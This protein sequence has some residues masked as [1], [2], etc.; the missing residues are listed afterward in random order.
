MSSGEPAL[1]EHIAE[2][3]RR[4]G[5]V[6]FA[7]LME[8]ALYHPEHGYY[9]S[10]RCTIGRAGDYFTSVSVGPLFGQLLAAQFAEMWQAMGRPRDF[11]IVE[12]AAHGGEFACD[13]L[14]AARRN[15]SEFFRA[16]R[17]EIIEP[18]P[19]L[20]ARQKKML[21]AFQDKVSWER[22]VADLAPFCGAH[23]SNELLDAM[24]IH[25]VKW[26]G[27]EWLERHVNEHNG[28]LVF[29]DLRLSQPALAE[30]LRK[31]AI[32]LPP[33]YESE[34]SLAT[35]SWIETLSRKLIEGF[36]LTVD[37][38]F[39]RDEYYSP[40]RARGT[41]RGYAKHEM[42]RSPLAQIG[43]ADITAHVE[44]TTLAECAETCGLVVAGFTDQH[45][46]ITGL[47]A[48]ETGRELVSSSDAKT[49]RALQTLLHPELLGRKFQCLILAKQI[50]QPS[51]LSGLRF[52]Q[53]L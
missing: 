48:S 15:D 2:T 4:E 19:V 46:L 16:L 36:V 51:Q 11:A 20:K 14:E 23:F 1:I 30:R 6:T 41:L 8:Q 35:A 28:A 45:H 31:V 44:W 29:E 21:A 17:Y 12:Q 7:W 33:D 50:A 47:L 43:R 38:G 34:V 13:V 52:P 42:V 37:Y 9:S 39:S 10:G 40:H 5:P 53:K 25:L 26:T 18:F 32:P 24:P 22:S 49:K 3:I 27:T